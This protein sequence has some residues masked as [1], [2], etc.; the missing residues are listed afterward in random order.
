M[1]NLMCGGLKFVLI[2]LAVLGTVSAGFAMA[3]SRLRVTQEPV[4]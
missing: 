3:Q 1:V 2:A 4:S